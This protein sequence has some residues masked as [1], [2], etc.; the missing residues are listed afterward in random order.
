M[1]SSMTP[2]TMI[3]GALWSPPLIPTPLRVRWNEA[4]RVAQRGAGIGPTQFCRT[5]AAVAWQGPLM[6]GKPRA[7]RCRS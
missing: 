1:P 4:W 7:P 2:L 3:G 6:G 5:N